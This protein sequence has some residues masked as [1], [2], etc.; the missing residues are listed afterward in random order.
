[1]KRIG[2]KGAHEIEHGN[3]VASFHAAREIGVD[4]IEF[5]IMRHP[6]EDR[7]NGQLVF[8]HD[9]TDAGNR[10]GSTLLTMEQG[11]DLLASPE[12]AD[13]GLDVDMKHR[14]FE[15]QVIDALRERGLI[16]RTM[17]TTMHSESLKLINEHVAPG[18]IKL[19]LTI[20]KVTKDWLNMPSVVKPIIVAG[21][22]EQRLRQPARVAKLIE[23]GE[24]QAVM[25]FYSLVSPR[26][27]KAV[28][29]AGGELYAWTVDD[30]ET[31]ERL[32][33]LGVDGIVSN[34]PRLFDE[35]D[36]RVDA[37]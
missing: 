7:Q 17:I 8:A 22:I 27:V 25:A 16:E 13:I 26:L 19:G 4:M 5:D 12:F 28:H 36:A 24:I 30:A 33:A 14:G 31:I 34:D 35:A 23:S 2:H 9:P 18:E 10:E 1:M 15:L 32:F 21:V 20:P 11:L 37:A 29:D 3:T 6:Y